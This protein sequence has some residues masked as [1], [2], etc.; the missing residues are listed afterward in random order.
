MYLEGGTEVIYDMILQHLIIRESLDQKLFICSESVLSRN[1]DDTSCLKITSSHPDP[2][3]RKFFV[4]I[5]IFFQETFLI[6]DKNLFIVRRPQNFKNSPNFF[7][8]S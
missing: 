6:T 8:L 1:F 5:P 2:D 7:K 3:P 4:K